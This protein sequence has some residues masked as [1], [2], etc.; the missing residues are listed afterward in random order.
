MTDKINAGLANP[1]LKRYEAEQQAKGTKKEVPNID[2]E[3]FYGNMDYTELPSV[4]VLDKVYIPTWNNKPADVP[5]VLKLGG[6]SILTHQNSS[7]IIANP[8]SGKSSIMEAILASYLNP[9][10]D[11]LG[12]EVDPN[13]RGVIYID[14]ERTNTD[15]WNSY[16]RMCRRAGIPEGATTNNILIA[17][18]RSIPRLAERM[19]VIEKLVEDNP[20]SLLLIDGAGD[21]VSD[22]NDLAQAIESRIWIREMTVK[23]NLSI[24]T[25]LHPNPNSNKPR[26][27]QGSEIC[28]E[29]ECV[30][31]VKSAEGDTRIITSDFEHG[32]NRNNPKLSTAFTWSE[33]FK[34]FITADLDQIKEAKQNA[35]DTLKRDQALKLAQQVI[36]A[37]NSMT[38]TELKSA[39]MRKTSKGDSTARKS[40]QDWDG[41]GIIHKRPDDRYQLTL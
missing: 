16:Y 7:G 2:P 28:R 10:C 4:N 24:V 6:C 23:Y 5:A 11:A 31:L 18:L 29:A 33:N 36:P 9:G 32:K 12:F 13:C 26:G 39:I 27:H 1:A 3:R 21:L 8:G 34:M 19:T 15:V 30:L 37:P 25:T 14:N 22:T 41:W 35:K 20:C 38:Y 17:G 40:I